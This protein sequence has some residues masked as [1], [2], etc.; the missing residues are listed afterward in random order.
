MTKLAVRFRNE[1]LHVLLLTISGCL[2]FV[3]LLL[4]KWIF[5]Y[6][7]RRSVPEPHIEPWSPYKQMK[8]RQDSIH[9]SMLV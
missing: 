1:P 4:T 6:Y 9:F 8:A 5:P 7:F 3:S 2:A